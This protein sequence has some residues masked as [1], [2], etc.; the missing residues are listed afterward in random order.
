MALKKDKKK[1][2][3]E[4]FTDD[5]VKEFLT[6]TNVGTTD[7]DFTALERAYRGMKADNFETFVKFFVEEGKNINCTN[8]NGDSFLQSIAKHRHAGPYLSALKSCGAK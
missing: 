1:V 5:R 7:P 8:A 2:I 3:G 6:V 4:T